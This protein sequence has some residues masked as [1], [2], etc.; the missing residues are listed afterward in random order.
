[1]GELRWKRIYDTA[2]ED[3]GFRI[4]ID[5]LWPRGISKA[6]AQLGDWARDVAPSAALRSAYHR[7]ETDYK[8]FAESYEKEL[9]DNDEMTEFI[10]E[11]KNKLETGNVTLLY[12]SREP[13][14][15][16]IPVLRSFI[17]KR[18]KE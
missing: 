18:L 4:L 13:E 3:D 7:N 17:E 8:T 16:Q 11:I 9:Y 2:E 15:S 5:R 14:R 6:D 12:A 10:K 1:M